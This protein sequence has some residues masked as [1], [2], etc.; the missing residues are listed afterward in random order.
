MLDLV[1]IK[2]YI[3][4]YSAV[5]HLQLDLQKLLI[6]SLLVLSHFGMDGIRLFMLFGYLN[7]IK[8][9]DSILYSK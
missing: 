8:M 3:F 7:K 4:I 2:K 5:S 1:R 9:Q 6:L